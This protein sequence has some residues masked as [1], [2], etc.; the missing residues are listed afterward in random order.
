MATFLPGCCCPSLI[1]DILGVLGTYE[2]YLE[3]ERPLP[4]RGYLVWL[5]KNFLRQKR[6]SN[7][8]L[9]QFILYLVALYILSGLSVSEPDLI[10]GPPEGLFLLLW[11]LVKY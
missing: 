9:R 6:Q 2:P 10:A 11:D 7:A 3:E 4:R 5:G 1:T 8:R